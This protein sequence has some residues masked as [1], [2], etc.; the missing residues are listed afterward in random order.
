M[1]VLAPVTI[2]FRPSSSTWLPP[3]PGILLRRGG[4][5]GA[6]SSRRACGRAVPNLHGGAR[7]PVAD[8]VVLPLPLDVDRRR[9]Q[10]QVAEGLRK[11]AQQRPAGRIDLF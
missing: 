4:R 10:R 6:L 2:A 8:Q 3:C 11:V 5:A 1:P 9:D 7:A